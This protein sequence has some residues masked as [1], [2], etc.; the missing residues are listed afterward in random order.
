MLQE[1][2]LHFLAAG[3]VL[4]AVHAWLNPSANRTGDR[5]RIVHIT[6]QDVAWLEQTWTR[7]WQRPPDEQQLRGLVSDYL[8]EQLL[9][10]EARA[11][12]LDENDTIVRRRLAQKVEFL[13]QDTAGITE[14]GEDELRRF[15][16]AN[17]E[18]FQIPARISF[19][20]VYF[21]GQSAES[22]AADALKTLRGSRPAS[23]IPGPGDRSLLAAEVLGEDEV[24]VAAVFGTEFAKQV[25]TLVPGQWHGPIRSG[26]GFHLV[27]VSE[28]QP[29]QPRELGAVR[30]QV[31]AEWRRERRQAADRAYLAGLLKKY[32][33]VV[34]ESIKPLVGP[35]D[36]AQNAQ[37]AE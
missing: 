13:V 5:S 1:P 14:P 26:Y 3:A 37:A 8:K 29:A 30:E 15:H 10:R 31:L 28:K 11:L 7:Q 33:V 9:A 20:Q 17:H 32:D 16:Q 18:R 2:L 36:V 21:A 23:G 27:R 12:G 6:A 19:R 35:L 22:R 34:D 25:F 4:F 24:S